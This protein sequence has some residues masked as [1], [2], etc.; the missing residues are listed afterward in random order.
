MGIVAW[1]VEALSG[2]LEVNLLTGHRKRRPDNV[3]LAGVDDSPAARFLG[4][5]RTLK[6]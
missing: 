4:R 5:H 6:G 2:V 3:A 1:I